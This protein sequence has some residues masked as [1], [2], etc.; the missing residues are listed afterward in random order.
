MLQ[1]LVL[2]DLIKRFLKTFNQLLS[3]FALFIGILVIIQFYTL[4]KSEGKEQGV[5][6]LM[7][8]I[9]SGKK[10]TQAFKIIINHFFKGL[11]FFAFSLY[12]YLIQIL[13]VKRLN[14]TRQFLSLLLLCIS[15]AL[16]WINKYRWTDLTKKKKNWIWTLKMICNL[17]FIYILL[18]FLIFLIYS[19]RIKWVWRICKYHF[20]FIIT[21]HKP[22]H[23]VLIKKNIVSTPPFKII[24]HNYIQ[25][26]KF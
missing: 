1:F 26:K 9:R 10:V 18:L 16:S 3:V 13:R 2:K 7:S 24:F 20:L 19:Y 6:D 17:Y 23:M 14:K 22:I 25:Y 12:K 21:T 11:F 5:L 8:D 15:S 4:R